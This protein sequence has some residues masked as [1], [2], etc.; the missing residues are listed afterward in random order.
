MSARDLVRRE[1]A[2]SRVA[3][4]HELVPK[5][6]MR[7]DQSDRDALIVGGLTALVMEEIHFGRM[8]AM[9]TPIPVATE[10]RL[11]S[12]TQDG[13][14]AAPYAQ[15]VE[16]FKRIEHEATL[17]LQR[18]MRRHPLGPWVKA[19]KGVGEKQGARL[20]AAIGDITYNHAV[21]RPR[22]GPAELWAYCGYHCLPAWDQFSS[23]AQKP[24]VPGGKTVAA[25]RQKGVRANW[26]ATAKMRA[27]LVAESCVKC[28]D[29]PY[30]VVYDKARASWADRDV[31]DGHKHNHA[32]RLVAKTVLKDLFLAARAAEGLSGRSAAQ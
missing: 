28:M 17:A 24:G 12:M 5:L 13:I 27:F 8:E 4:P 22:R 14:E 29:S 2:R 11:R 15:Q 6:L 26:N 18:V 30:R 19:T 10:N 23:V 16:V 1:L 7:I 3:N 21:G 32:L 31:K 20:I 9:E 25:K